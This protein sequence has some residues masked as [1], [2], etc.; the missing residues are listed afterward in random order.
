MINE[1][2][3][4]GRRFAPL[5]KIRKLLKTSV[6][7]KSFDQAPRY[8]MGL[9]LFAS[10]LV[11]ISLSI[12]L[13]ILIWKPISA[14]RSTLEDF[15]WFF[16]FVFPILVSMFALRGL[17]PG[18]GMNRV[19]E[20]KR[21]VITTVFGNVMTMSFM[22]LFRIIFRGDAVVF[23]LL[24]ILS[25]GL[26][27]L[28]RWIVRGGL[29][30]LHLWGEPVIV[31]G[32]GDESMELLDH[33]RRF[34][35]LGWR[36]V[37]VVDGSGKAGDA[38]K[39]PLIPGNAWVEDTAIASSY[40]NVKTAIISYSEVTEPI[41]S[42]LVNNQLNGFSRLIFLS[43]WEYLRKA[44]VTPVDLG[45]L[46]GLEVQ[47]NLLKPREQLLKRGLDLTVVLIA[48]VLG[49]P[50]IFLLYS[51]V[52]IDSKGKPFYKH[53][54]IGHKGKQFALWKFRTMVHDADEK[55]D[56]YLEQH[57][58]LKAE[59]EAERKLQDDPRITRVGR[60]LRKLSLDEIPQLWNVLKGEM[61]LVG[62]RPIVDLEIERYADI[63]TLYKQVKPGITGL[64]QVSGRNLTG[65]RER[66]RLDEYY[67]RN[68][69]I[70]MDMYILVRTVW[71]VIRVRGAF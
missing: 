51:L 28:S 64:W 1:Q 65:Y 58:E 68:W 31:F 33:L 62:P 69:S 15:F 70:W 22:L 20:L 37:A 24:G 10:D 26:I 54:R 13:A 53:A 14:D 56:E 9:G 71:V 38:L 60:I 16:Q 52:L 25:L 47:Q 67:V 45:G 41:L 63:F 18:I 11:S 35:K 42:Q 21:L 8:W 39:I 34:K 29:I 23:V 7:G 3:Q 48:A 32:F 57:P 5:K 12:W 40:Q 49:A 66:I 36:A 43:G 2:T 30:H 59:W 4:Q 46:L 27:P 44:W 50:F 19:V 55:L 6:I 61:S 17:Y